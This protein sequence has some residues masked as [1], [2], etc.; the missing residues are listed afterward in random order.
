MVNDQIT[1]PKYVCKC[2]SMGVFANDDNDVTKDNVNNVTED[3]NEVAE[4]KRGQHSTG[5]LCTVKYSV[6]KKV[7]SMWAVSCE[8]L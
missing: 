8:P 4:V 5:D 1:N 7:G 6:D 3:N 2:A